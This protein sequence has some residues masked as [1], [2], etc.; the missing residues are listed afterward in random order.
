[1]QCNAAFELAALGAAPIQLL[2]GNSTR[3]KI[4]RFESRGKTPKGEFFEYLSVN[5][6]K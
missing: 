3:F 1:V 2:R 5:A 4:D 6:K